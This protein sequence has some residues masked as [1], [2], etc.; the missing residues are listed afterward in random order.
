MATF[1]IVLLVLIFLVLVGFLVAAIVYGVS[2]S[3][4]ITSLG[5]QLQVAIQQSFVIFEQ[6]VQNTVKSLQDFSDLA[7]SSIK[8]FETQAVDSFSS[9]ATYFRDQIGNLLDVLTVQVV[10]TVQSLGRMFIKALQSVGSAVQDVLNEVITWSGGVIESVAGLIARAFTLVGQLISALVV[11][12]VQGV[13]TA[14]TKILDELQALI[15]TIS[16]G[17]TFVV[18]EIKDAIT[19]LHNAIQTGLDAITSIVNNINHAITVTLPQDLLS[20]YNA[21]ISAL[22]TLLDGFLCSVVAP[23]CDAIAIVPASVCNSIRSAGGC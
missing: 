2:L 8:Q 13:T 4:Q 16:G 5:S 14:I 17:V 6:L 1:D 19:E 22:S 10:D 12:I 15:E 11:F 21:V 7:I 20:A 18:Q 3:G 9:V 23:L